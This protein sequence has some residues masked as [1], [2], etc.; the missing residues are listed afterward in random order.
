[1]YC[2]R[3]RSSQATQFENGAALSWIRAPSRTLR[4]FALSSPEAAS[5]A[6]SAAVSAS[7]ERVALLD[8]R[9]SR[10]ASCS[11]CFIC[12]SSLCRAH[13]SA[14]RRARCVAAGLHRRPYSRA[15]PSNAPSVVSRVFSRPLR[16]RQISRNVKMSSFMVCLFPL[17][18]AL[19]PLSALKAAGKAVVRK[20]ALKRCIWLHIGFET[21]FKGPVTVVQLLNAE[22]LNRSKRAR[23]PL[24]E[25]EKIVRSRFASLDAQP[26]QLERHLPGGIEHARGAG[27]AE[28]RLSVCCA[29]NAL[30]WRASSIQCRFAPLIAVSADAASRI[31]GARQR[32]SAPRGICQSGAANSNWHRS[33]RHLSAARASVSKDRGYVF[34]DAGSAARAFFSDFPCVASAFSAFGIAAGSHPSRCARR[35]L[36]RP[37][38]SPYCLRA[39]ASGKSTEKCSSA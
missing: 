28:S 33:K 11:C 20:P 37:H 25:T 35:N 6:L 30:R 8:A 17:C 2:L 22:L 13:I 7:P 23:Q 14:L 34:S 5:D 4:I 15:M 10:R 16:A 27:K 38:R 24:R 36:L 9:A 31:S 1:M 39:R 26:V 18:R 21:D 32:F 3:M 29:R 12:A 19:N